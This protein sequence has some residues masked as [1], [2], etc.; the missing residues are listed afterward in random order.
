MRITAATAPACKLGISP[1]MRLT[2]AR[3]ICPVLG[4]VPHDRAADAALLDMMADAMLRFTPWVALDGTDGLMLDVTGCA[5]LAGGETA[6]IEAVRVVFTGAGFTART[7]LGD[8]IGVAWAL[9]RYGAAPG[10]EISGTGTEAA[11]APLPLGALRLAPATLDKLHQLGLKTIGQLARL[12]RASLMRRFP[13]N[14]DDPGPVARLDQALRRRDEPLSPRAEAPDYRV[15]VSPLEPLI[16]LAGIRHHFNDLLTNL[17]GVL[18]GDRRGARRLTLHAFRCDGPVI[19]IPVGLARASRETDHIIRLF[20]EKLTE[21]DPGF[22]VDTLMLSADVTE[23][24]TQQ[25]GTLEPAPEIAAPDA[26]ER[27]VDRIANRLGPDSIYRLAP[28]A[29]HIPDRAV[30]RAEPT[31]APDW[32]QTLAPLRPLTLLTRPEPIAVMAEIPEG[33][34]V[35]FRWRRVLHKVV[36]ATGPERLA[37]EWWRDLAERARSRD[38]YAIEDDGGGRYWLFRDGL[39]HEA[40]LRGQPEWF[41]HG[42]F[43]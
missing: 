15:R 1:G 37:P 31:R 17:M 27:L 23:L 2:D 4:A 33:P 16:D 24:L 43:A 30:R 41:L 32:S 28:V 14:R 5:H 26:L 25:Q 8:T 38:Y 22:G 35:S 7:G 21:I 20:N 9:A 12:D 10:Q 18:A 34:P 6:L 42:I 39:Y 40:D 36:R 3:A 29:S 11:L 19:R 13:P